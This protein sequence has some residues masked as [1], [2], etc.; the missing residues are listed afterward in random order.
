MT[1][2]TAT[3]YISL[4]VDCPKCG[5]NF[6]LLSDTSLNDEGGLLNDAISDDRW[7]IPQDERIE[8]ESDC[9]E[10]KTNV[11]VKGLYW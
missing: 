1:K 10:C 3:L 11:K 7:K 9:P 8:C 5:H 2:V 6:D 4:D